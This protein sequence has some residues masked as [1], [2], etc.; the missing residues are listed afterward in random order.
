MKNAYSDIAYEYI[1]KRIL[2][3]TFRPGQ[4]LMSHDLSVEIGISRT[5]IRDA[6]R[7]LETDGLVVIRA[8]LGASV[9]TMDVNEYREMCGLRLALEVYAAGLAAGQR[10]IEELHE[11]EEALE[12]MEQLTKAFVESEAGNEEIIQALRREDV[13]F[14]VAIISAARS[15][16]LKKEVFRLHIVDRVVSG[17]AMATD[18]SKAESDV[19]RKQAQS[20]HEEIYRAIE[21]RDSPEAKNA[22]EKHIRTII[23]NVIRVML[24][25]QRMSGSRGLTE[26]E[27]GYMA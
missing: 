27:L 14:H 3:G 12:K 16:L 4:Q 26:E 1:R 5:P 2:N 8:N 17:I 20:S 24:R 15:E 11:M 22:M 13:R 6:L 21:R 19:R 18:Q 9:K 7:Q 10:T 25:T 23:N